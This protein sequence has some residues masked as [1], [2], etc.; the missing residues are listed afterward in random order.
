VIKSQTYIRQFLFMRTARVAVISKYW[1]KLEVLWWAQK[2][3]KDITED[4]D[5]KKAKNKKKKKKDDGPGVRISEYI[6]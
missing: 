3:S 6:S 1:D 5:D 2:G 4:I